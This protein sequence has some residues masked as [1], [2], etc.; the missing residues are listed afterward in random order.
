[1]PDPQQDAAN[2]E[3]LLRQ[4]LGG[5]ELTPPAP[6]APVASHPARDA[7]VLESRR[8][9]DKMIERARIN[10]TPEISLGEM[11]GIENDWQPGMEG[12]MTRSQ[13]DRTVELAMAFMGGGGAAGTLDDVAAKMG[14]PAGAFKSV[15]EQSPTHGGYTITIRDLSGT[16]SKKYPTQAGYMD[17]GSDAIDDHLRVDNVYVQPEYRGKG[18]GT[19]IYQE[20]IEEAKRQGHKGLASDPY[21]RNQNSN[22]IWALDRP[23]ITQ[24]VKDNPGYYDL[25]SEYQPRPGEPPPSPPSVPEVLE[26]LQFEPLE[27]TRPVMR[28]GP[29]TPAYR[30]SAQRLENAIS[31][32]G[33]PRASEALEPVASHPARSEVLL[34]S[35]KPGRNVLDLSKPFSQEIEADITRA[36]GTDQ[37]SINMLRQRLQ[38]DPRF[39]ARLPWDTYL[40][41]NQL[42]TLS[43]KK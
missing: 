10:E 23:G 11:R 18:M 5:G 8:R 19:E 36:F 33:R 29:L 3:A 40:D 20:A 38:N 2:R 9:G 39:D 30:A 6:I 34:A 25:M 17:F 35:G 1:M 15:V 12:Q 28:G 43:P 41:P 27:A 21:S 4:L 42:G 31:R 7:V 24:S 14:K 22:R 32:I 16:G 26:P 37:W 13:W